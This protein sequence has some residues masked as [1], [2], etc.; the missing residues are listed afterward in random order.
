MPRD[1]VRESVSLIL[2]VIN[3]CE[4]ALRSFGSLERP[5]TSFAPRRSPSSPPS[6][7]LPS[8]FRKVV[9]LVQVMG[10]QQRKK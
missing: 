8:F 5:L 7:H 9:R 2:D 10:L 4:P 1:P 6:S 3:L